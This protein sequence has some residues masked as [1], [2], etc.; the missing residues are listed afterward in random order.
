MN[1]QNRVSSQITVT[2]CH[3][4]GIKNKLEGNGLFRGGL[5]EVWHS[6]HSNSTQYNE[7]AYEIRGLPSII[8]TAK[9]NVIDHV[10]LSN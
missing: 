2:V 10:V 6:L 9:N 1:D 5:G 4:S 7:V 8:N 3:G